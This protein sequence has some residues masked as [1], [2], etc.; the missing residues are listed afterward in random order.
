[1]HIISS[2]SSLHAAGKDFLTLP[3]HSSLSYLAFGKSSIVHPVTVQN[4]FRYVLVGRPALAHLF[5]NV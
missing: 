4:C 2:S 1:M 5:E 3:S